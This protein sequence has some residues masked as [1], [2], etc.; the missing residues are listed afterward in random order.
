MGIRVQRQ[1]ITWPVRHRGVEKSMTTEK[2]HF[3]KEKET[4]LITLYSR[5]VESRSADSV[6]HDTWADEAIRRIDYDFTK[7][8][9]RKIEPLSIAIRARQFDLLTAAYL[10]EHPQATVV[11]MGC[12][13]DSRIFRVDP[14]ASVS[15]FD[16]DY[17]E[18]IALRR[19]LYP[20][21]VGYHLIG[22]SLANVQWLDEVP[23]D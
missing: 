5:A 8:K 2:V 21:R 14:P 10:A 20:E 15:W 7:L 23:R 11:H 9:I 1:P 18:V 19:Q 6:L 17:P 12:G 4:M 3:T 13:M 22:S 16:V